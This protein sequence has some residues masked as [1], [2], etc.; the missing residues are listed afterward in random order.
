[1]IYLAILFALIAKVLSPDSQGR[2]QSAPATSGEDRSSELA[3]VITDPRTSS[4]DRDSALSALAMVDFEKAVRLAPSLVDEQDPVFRV[5]A[6]WILAE[7]GHDKGKEVLRTV[8]GSKTEE[9]A[10]AVEALGRLRDPGSRELLRE[11]LTQELAVSGKP[12]VSS[13]VLAL[14]QALGD[15]ADGRD[16][17]LLARAAKNRWT[18]GDWVM[19]DSV[20]RTAGPDAVPVLEEIFERGKGW[21]VM[22][23]GLGLARCGSAKGAQYVRDRLGDARHDPA[24]PNQS[25]FTDSDTDDPQGPKATDFILTRLGVPADEMFVPELMRIVSSSLYSST[26]KAQAWTALARINPVRDRKTILSAA[27]NDLL[28]TGAIRLVVQNDEPRAQAFVRQNERS[29]EPLQ[30]AKANELRRALLAPSMVRR[31]WREIHGYSF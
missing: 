17:A 12:G 29:D 20:G 24:Q 3:R 6:A 30:R 23:A 4:E 7:G 2:A 18:P 13:A 25:R 19:V 21:T 28:S 5:R 14:V 27:W 26:A 22:A 11:L 15:Y 10:M 31:Q 1:M 9:S 16:A 8:A